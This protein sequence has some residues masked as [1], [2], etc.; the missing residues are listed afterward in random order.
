DGELAAFGV[1]KC[2]RRRCGTARRA[3]RVRGVGRRSWLGT[4]RS[5]MW[6]HVC[7]ARPDQDVASLID[8]HALAL[9]EFILQIVER[10][11]LQL[12]LPL[13]GAVGQAPPA[14]EH[15][16]RLVENLLKGHRSPFTAGATVSAQGRQA[17]PHPRRD[18]P[19]ARCPA[20]PSPRCTGRRTRSPAGGA[21]C[22]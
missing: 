20:F 8:R 16:D 19:T 21:W 18:P 12:E 5:D 3:L 9:D 22:A 10:C 6:G 13:E 11:L 7:P 1:R 4:R 15:R 2:R 14:L 17:L